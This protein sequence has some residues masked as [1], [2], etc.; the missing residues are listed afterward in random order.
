MML[1]SEVNVVDPKTSIE[2]PNDPNMPELKDIVYSDY[3]EVVGARGD[4]NNLD[5]L[6]PI[7]PIHN[8]QNS[9]NNMGTDDEDAHERVRRVLDITDLFHIPG[10]TRDVVMLRIFHITLTE[11][12]KR[13]K[14]M[15]PARERIMDKKTQSSPKRTKYEHEKEKSVKSQGQGLH[16]SRKTQDEPVKSKNPKT[17]QKN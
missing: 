13:W 9:R 4:I 1:G 11:A 16:L 10:V 15:L 7:S 17:Q 6:I 14:N 12:A 2:L 5:T 3:D 8:Y